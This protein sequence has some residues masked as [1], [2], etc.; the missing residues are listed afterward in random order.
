VKAGVA[1]RVDIGVDMRAKLS[2]ANV[3]ENTSPNFTV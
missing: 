1:A 2:Y 3:I